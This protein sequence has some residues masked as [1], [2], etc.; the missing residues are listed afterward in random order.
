MDIRNIPAHILYSREYT[1][2][3][4]VRPKK[5]LKRERSNSLPS[6]LIADEPELKQ[7]VTHHQRSR[8]SPVD[9]SVPHF[10]SQHHQILPV[11]EENGDD[12]R[13]SYSSADGSNFI[14]SDLA[15]EISQNDSDDGGEGESV[16][17]VP[18]HLLDSEEGEK[19]ESEGNESE[20]DH[21]Q[22]PKYMLDDQSNDNLESETDSRGSQS[23]SSEKDHVYEVPKYMTEKGQ[24]EE[25]GQEQG[26]EVDS[27]DEPP[28]EVPKFLQNCSENDDA[29]FEGKV[30]NACA[31]DASEEP[32]AEPACEQ[33]KQSLEIR[34]QSVDIP[35]H[36][37]VDSSATKYSTN[38][39][40]PPHLT[41]PVEKHANKMPVLS[42]SP[43]EQKEES[44]IPETNQ[45]EASVPTKTANRPKSTELS[46]PLKRDNI[47]DTSNEKNMM[48][49]KSVR[50]RNV[51]DKLPSLPLNSKDEKA[52]QNPLLPAKRNVYR[53]RSNSAPINN[54]NSKKEETIDIADDCEMSPKVPSK[55]KVYRQ[56]SKSLPTGEIDSTFS[57]CQ[58]ETM[59]KKKKTTQGSP[60]NGSDKRASTVSEKELPP[61]VP[62]KLNVYRQ[63]SNSLL[64]HENTS[65]LHEPQNQIIQR[66]S[67]TSEGFPQDNEE[68]IPKKSKKGYVMPRVPTKHKTYR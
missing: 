13:R 10:A 37:H 45:I 7:L 32:P 20:E 27:D 4:H 58:N 47:L 24:S 49:P 35:E 65:A 19:I 30:D 68:D 33:S 42:N 60:V 52:N 26:E 17:Q 36:S 66:P 2:N 54:T 16:Y 11:V 63:R 51:L 40:E 57:D 38:V 64:T 62:T 67:S 28:Y 48:P 23:E 21:Y 50:H 61:T 6:Q 44:N 14:S 29:F 8:S 25:D 3:R 22:V 39:P 55:H 46:N 9:L 18:K 53:Q 43:I 59:A 31:I 56:R 41:S 15:H 12:I 1:D 5:E 34:E